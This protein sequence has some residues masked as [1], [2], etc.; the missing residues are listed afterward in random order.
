MSLEQ[1]LKKAAKKHEASLPDWQ[2]KL[3]K[4]ESEGGYFIHFSFVPRMAFNPV[5]IFNTPL[6]F[7][8][9]PLDRNK[10]SDF[11][12]NRPY[13]IIVR[14]TSG[15]NNLNIK[16]YSNRE[17]EADVQKL[18]KMG[19]SLDKINSA[20]KEARVKNPGGKLWNITRILTIPSRYV[21]GEDKKTNKLPSKS[22]IIK[23]YQRIEHNEL[24]FKKFVDSLSYLERAHLAQYIKQKK[25]NDFLSGS[26]RPKWEEEFLYKERI[27]S[28]YVPRTEEDVGGGPTLAWSNLIKKLGYDGV[29]DDCDSVIHPHEPCQAVFFNLKNLELIEIIDLPNHVKKKNNLFSQLKSISSSRKFDFIKLRN[30]LSDSSTPKEILN[31]FARD[32]DTNFRAQIAMHTNTPPNTLKLLSKD[33]DVTVRQT[34]AENPNTPDD[35]LIEFSKKEELITNV[36]NNPKITNIPEVL[37]NLARSNYYGANLFLALNPSTP[38]TILLSLLAR[39]FDYS[40]QITQNPNVTGKVVNIMLSKNNYYNFRDLIYN[41][42]LNP[43]IDNILIDPLLTKDNLLKIRNNIS[44]SATQNLI[45]DILDNKENLASDEKT[46]PKTLMILSKDPDPYIRLSIAKNPNITIPII[47]NLIKSIDASKDTGK[48]ILLALIENPKIPTKLAN[49]IT[50]SYNLYESHKVKKFSLSKIIFIN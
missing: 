10:M 29:I 37:E 2:E 22:D 17:F 50:N 19:F 31:L 25:K 15:A 1:V 4:Y 18:L 28:S 21:T 38:E 13:A 42:S 47:F 3:L 34:V 11:A 44:N 49:I 9:Y 48:E 27:F 6:G 36:L 35:V 45:D 24:E 32:V 41:L 46:D 39:N 7:Y 20:I 43:N 14:P 16:N 40:N 5:N 30:I 23:R 12:I 33:P 8:S 26:Y